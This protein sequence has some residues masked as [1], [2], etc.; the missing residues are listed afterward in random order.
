M[1]VCAHDPSVYT[2]PEWDHVQV[3]QVRVVKDYRPPDEQLYQGWKRNYASDQPLLRPVEVIG[4]FEVHVLHFVVA[5]ALEDI[6]FP[7]H[8]HWKLSWEQLWRDADLYRVVEGDHAMGDPIAEGDLVI[9]KAFDVLGLWEPVKDAEL[10]RRSLPA[11]RLAAL[12]R[13]HAWGLAGEGTPGEFGN[14]YMSIDA[15]LAL[16]DEVE[17]LRGAQARL[18]EVEGTQAQERV[19]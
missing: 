8:R 17:V 1:G 3:D 16:C 18:D 4:K 6:I 19:A 13:L 2:V 12:D 11:R 5:K 9:F 7:P 10:H 15:V 14:A